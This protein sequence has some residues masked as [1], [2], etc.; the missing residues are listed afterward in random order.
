[1]TAH[2]TGGGGV[3]LMLAAYEKVGRTIDVCPLRFSIIHGNFFTPESMVRAQRL[4]VIADMQPAWFYKDADAMNYILGDE[5]IRTFHPYR[6]M[7][8][9]TTERGT[10]IVPE[11]AITRKQALRC[12]TMNNARASF[13][14]TLKG[15]I[16]PGKLADMVVIDRDFLACPEETIQDIRVIMT[17]V[18]GEVVFGGV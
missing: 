16:E 18:G 7:T 5:R 15:S 6:S 9:R 3:D 4:D 12:Y 13:E 2:C 10:V 11:E 14:E 8:A 1:M 17:V